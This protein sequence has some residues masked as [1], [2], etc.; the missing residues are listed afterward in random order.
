MKNQSSCSAGDIET[1]V[2]SLGRED[3]LEKEL[4]NALQYS[5]LGN[6]MDTGAWWATV[7]GGRKESDTTERLSYNNVGD[8]RGGQVAAGGRAAQQAPGSHPTT[9]RVAPCSCRASPS[10]FLLRRW[11]RPVVWLCGTRTS[12]APALVFCGSTPCLMSV[13]RRPTSDS[14]PSYCQGSPTRCPWW[15]NGHFSHFWRG[16]ILNNSARCLLTHVVPVDC[17]CMPVSPFHPFKFV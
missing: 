4:A 6:P 8:Q 17:W 5:C 1:W 12:G 11:L 3:P 10:H 2:P 13:L 15:V 7:L 9:A 14:T 16:T